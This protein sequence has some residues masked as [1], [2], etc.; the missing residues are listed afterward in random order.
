MS[1]V[2]DWGLGRL[3]GVDGGWGMPCLSEPKYGTQSGR[4]EPTPCPLPKREG[5]PEGHGVCWW[6]MVGG[7]GLTVLTFRT[8]LPDRRTGWMLGAIGLVWRVVLGV[9]GMGVDG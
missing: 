2:E 4:A 5:V 6:S 1:S 9:C 7:T 3:L 8:V